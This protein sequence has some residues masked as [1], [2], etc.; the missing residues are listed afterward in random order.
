MFLIPSG[1]NAAILNPENKPSKVNWA[2]MAQ[3]LGHVWKNCYVARVNERS[4]SCENG[5]QARCYKFVLGR[6]FLDRKNGL[7]RILATVVSLPNTAG[8]MNDLEKLATIANLD[9]NQ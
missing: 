9:S 4:D 3:C 8:D 5:R 7:P 1:K 2:L 6:S